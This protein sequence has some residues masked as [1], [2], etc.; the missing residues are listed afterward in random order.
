MKKI[1]RRKVR[2]V[3][4]IMKIYNV[5]SNSNSNRDTEMDIN[6]CID[7]A[8]WKYIVKSGNDFS[9]IEDDTVSDKIV[10]QIHDLLSLDSIA[11]SNILIKERFA[12]LKKY[13]KQ[14]KNL[15]E[16]PQVEQRSK[17][18]HELRRNRLTAS[19]TATA[20]GRGKFETRKNLLKKK[21]FPDSCPFVSSPIMK[22]GTMFEPMADR[23]YRQRNG[24]IISHEFGLIPH[25]D[26]DHYGASPD[27]ITE[28]G[29]MLEFKCPPKRKMDGTIPEQYEI[30]MQGQLAVCSLKE[31]DYVEC[32]LD[33]FASIEEYKAAISPVSKTDHGIILEYCENQVTTFD[34]SPEYMT[35]E[36]VSVWAQ[37][38][39]KNETKHLVKIIP[40]RLREY[41]TQRVYFDSERWITI[42][43][44]INQFWKEVEELRERGEPVV[45]ITNE[46]SIPKRREKIIKTIDFIDDTSDDET[47]TTVNM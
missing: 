29:I 44:E 38:R 15:Q 31:C 35:S 6:H 1:E 37:D 25:P 41:F 26:V 16:Q 13:R 32:G 42:L 46:K 24:D 21:A 17:E 23:S 28:L 9:C 47:C 45:T 36:E 43:K 39:I 8:I 11:M 4:R 34:Y 7:K 19:D 30:Q 40:W 22:W 18:W 10:T 2:N 20:M 3:L 33:D 27:G 12:N 14:L 5:V